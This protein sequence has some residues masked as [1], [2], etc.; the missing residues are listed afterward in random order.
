MEGGTDE[1]RREDRTERED[2]RL[3]HTTNMDTVTGSRNDIGD[4][5]L[6][7]C[8][9]K[10]STQDTVAPV[11]FPQKTRGRKKAIYHETLRAMARH[12]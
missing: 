5:T 11:L 4:K 12:I 7:Y 8:A 10:V 2:D 6:N 3:K 9:G 1:Q